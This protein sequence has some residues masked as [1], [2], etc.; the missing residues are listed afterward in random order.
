M[1]NRLI[2]GAAFHFHADRLQKPAGAQHIRVQ[3][4]HRGRK[5]GQGIALRRKVEHIVRPDVMDHPHKRH[6]VIQIR[7]LKKYP[8][9]AVDPLKQVRHII[10]RTS[11]AA[12]AVHVPV[13]MHQQVIRKMRPHHSCNSRN[14]RFYLHSFTPL[15]SFCIFSVNAPFSVMLYGSKYRLFICVIRG[16]FLKNSSPVIVTV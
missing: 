1:D 3:R 6:L 12:D 14:Q 13:C 9:P 15:S 10:K 4:V 8:F 2:S 11:P 16:R 5:R 7:I